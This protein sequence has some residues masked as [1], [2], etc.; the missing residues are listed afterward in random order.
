MEIL[1]NLFPKV[2]TNVIITY[3]TDI[4]NTQQRY[5]RKKRSLI[6]QFLADIVEDHM[7]MIIK[8]YFM[9]D[10]ENDDD[11]CAGFDYTRALAIISSSLMP[12]CKL[13]TTGL[14]V[15]TGERGE[16]SERGER[17]ERSDT[18]ERGERGERSDSNESC[19]DIWAFEINRDQNEKK[20]LLFYYDDPNGY[21]KTRVPLENL[22]LVYH[23]LYKYL[24][25]WELL[26]AD[27][28]VNMSKVM[29]ELQS[30]FYWL[31]DFL[32]KDILSL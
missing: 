10:T 13:N 25:L 20:E 12:I 2:I 23:Q 28:A 22:P 30:D 19:R 5:S 27:K 21:S 32:N 7:R 9:P 24:R 29:E 18:G 8:D 3:A 26:M 1:T 4:I 31:T 15:D 11:Y 6:K 16:S 14:Q 17:G